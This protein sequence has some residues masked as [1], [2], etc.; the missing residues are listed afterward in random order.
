MKF[1]F[2]ISEKVKFLIVAECFFRIALGL[3]L[4]ILYVFVLHLGGNLSHLGVIFA[5]YGVVYAV[6]S[7]L[8][9]VFLLEYRHVLFSFS[10]L[11]WSIYAFLMFN[12]TEYYHVYMLQFIAG[13][14][15]AFGNPGMT[16]IIVLNTE[17]NE[18]T[19][20]SGFYKLLGS[21]LGA[22]AA[23]VSGW[24]GHHY[25]IRPLFLAMSIIAFISFIISLKLL[26]IKDYHE[27]IE[28]D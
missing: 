8:I 24:L 16:Q 26:K 20:T 4:P 28:E 22:I 25:E 27:G 15:T 19:E 1:L 7:F 5:I 23:Y 18:Y 6:A 13:L 2:T 9:S 10:L 12:V 14:S 3:Q 17:K 11:L 21:F